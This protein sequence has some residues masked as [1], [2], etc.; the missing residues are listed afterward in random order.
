MTTDLFGNPVIHVAKKSK[1]AVATKKLVA[2]IEEIS[3][4]DMAGRGLNGVYAT[5]KFGE[6]IVENRGNKTP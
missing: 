4:N 3:S 1:K 6:W 2:H 5:G